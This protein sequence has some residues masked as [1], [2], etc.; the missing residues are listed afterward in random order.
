MIL[1]SYDCVTAFRLRFSK[2]VMRLSTHSTR[3]RER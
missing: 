1:A 3:V 2:K